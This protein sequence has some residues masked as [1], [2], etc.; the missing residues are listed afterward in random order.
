M[1]AKLFLSLLRERSE[2]LRE[3]ATAL[4]TNLET[5]EQAL[6]EQDI[7]PANSALLP[8]F[9]ELNG[10]LAATAELFC[11]R[12]HPF[13]AKGSAQLPSEALQSTEDRNTPRPRPAHSEF[14]SSV[15]KSAEGVL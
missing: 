9:A 5:L 13:L 2:Q 12:L 8:W 11:Q 15:S 6:G 1:K 4:S 3:L 7:S 10:C 14:L